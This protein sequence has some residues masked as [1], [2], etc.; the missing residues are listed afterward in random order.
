MVWVF[1]VVLFTAAVPVAAVGPPVP[2]TPP[3][4]VVDLAGVIDDDVEARTNTLLR[5]LEQ[6][7][8]AQVVV[9]TLPTLEGR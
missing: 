1:A 8:T 5:E 6:Q 4:Y 7:T 9:L 3:N 2:A